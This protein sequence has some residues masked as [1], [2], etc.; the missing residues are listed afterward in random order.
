MS[1][2]D[3]VRGLDVVAAAEAG[4]FCLLSSGDLATAGLDV[5]S[6]FYAGPFVGLEGEAAPPPEP[7]AL[8]RSYP[9]MPAQRTFPAVPAERVFPL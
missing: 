5:V 9:G 1:L 8:S 2:I 7:G 4:P 3:S 6:C